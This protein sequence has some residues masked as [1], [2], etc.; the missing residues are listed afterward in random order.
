MNL[1]L[2]HFICDFEC[3]WDA[4]NVVDKQFLAWALMLGLKCYQS[5]VGMEFEWG[6]IALGVE[7]AV[8][9]Q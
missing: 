9:S 8:R 5:A 3:N 2:L 7:F 1:E 4:T 6:S